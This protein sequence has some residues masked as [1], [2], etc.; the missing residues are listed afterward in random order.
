VL[1]AN[2]RVIV[3]FKLSKANQALLKKLKKIRSVTTLR[4]TNSAGKTVAGTSRKI[5]LKR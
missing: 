1:S 5:V 2:G 4:V 3:K